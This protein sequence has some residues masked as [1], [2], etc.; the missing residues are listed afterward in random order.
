MLS[1]TAWNTFSLIAAAL[2][3]V[4]GVLGTLMVA[5]AY[6]P[7]GV[8]DFLRSL[9]SFLG[10]ALTFR[11]KRMHR[12]LEIAQRFAGVN[13]EDRALS[14]MGI[15]LVFLGFAIQLVGAVCAFLGTL[16]DSTTVPKPPG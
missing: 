11:R 9:P 4:V 15:C 16:G 3:A 6:Y 10:L 2:G 7:G 5:N 13:H 8:W 14:L 1:A 12:R